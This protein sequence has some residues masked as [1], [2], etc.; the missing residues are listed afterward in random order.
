MINKFNLCPNLAQS[1]PMLS[2]HLILS[3]TILASLAACQKCSINWSSLLICFQSMLLI[4]SITY[5]TAFSLKLSA[6]TP[7]FSNS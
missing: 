7:S 1:L 3:R 5:L 2:F 4:S 6:D